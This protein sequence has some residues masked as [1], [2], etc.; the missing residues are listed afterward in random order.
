[1]PT[2]AFNDRERALENEFFHRVDQQ[3]MDKLRESMD[4]KAAKEALAEATHL[5]D[6][7]LLDELI[8]HGFSTD[9]LVALSLAPMVIVAWADHE[10][11]AAERQTILEASLEKGMT[12]DSLG[13][14]LLQ[15][16]LET[17]PG[18]DLLLTWKHYTE[19]ICK[20]LG[21]PARDKLKEEVM[22]RAKRVAEASGG[23]LGFGKTSK[24]ER[25]VLE[26]IEAA[27]SA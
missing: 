22:S 17:E 23:I 20:T 11:K 6:D 7:S 2:G 24:V 4:Q 26:E 13:G 3:L 15:S 16:W 19:A 27:F 14:H 10:L 21:A 9:S 1:M 12:A 5:T 18:A 8:E 25:N